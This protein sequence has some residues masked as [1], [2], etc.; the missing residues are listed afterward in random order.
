VTPE[1]RNA[2][3]EEVAR[4]VKALGLADAVKS[5]G[6]DIKPED[7]P[8]VGAAYDACEWAIHDLKTR[9][10]VPEGGAPTCHCLSPLCG[11]CRDHRC[12]TCAIC[13]PVPPAPLAPHPEVVDRSLVDELT[14]ALRLA[15]R[16]HFST[17][18]STCHVCALLALSSSPPS[19]LRTAEQE[20]ERVACAHEFIALKVILNSSLCVPCQPGRYHWPSHICS[21]CGIKVCGDHLQTPGS[22]PKRGG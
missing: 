6:M 4:V 1:D 12:Q 8:W 14:R 11:V 16:E 3:L 2:V 10:G 18:Q 5:R 9:P 20:R 13:T 21:N 7:V 19:L 15:H 22:D 17:P